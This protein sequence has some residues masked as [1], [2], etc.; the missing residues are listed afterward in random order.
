MKESFDF[1]VNFKIT[2]ADAFE[3]MERKCD[4]FVETEKTEQGVKVK[5]GEDIKKIGIQYTTNKEAVEEKTRQI[6]KAKRKM[7]DE[8]GA[9]KEKETIED[10][11]LVV[12]PLDNIKRIFREWQKEGRKPGGPDKLWDKKIKEQ[13]FIG[14]MAKALNEK[15]ARDIWAQIENKL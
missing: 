13:I 12:I 6:A 15:E 8:A 10:I 11:V 3:D 1:P 5:T 2:E 4:F 14:V 7:Q 9:G